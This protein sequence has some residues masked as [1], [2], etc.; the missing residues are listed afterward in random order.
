M[1][2]ARSIE[3]IAHESVAPALYLPPEEIQKLKP[4]VNTHSTERLRCRAH[5]G[6]SVDRQD[7]IALGELQEYER[8]QTR[9]GTI[10]LASLLRALPAD[11]FNIEVDCEHVYEVGDAGVLVHNACGDSR[12]LGLD[13]AMGSKTLAKGMRQAGYQAGHIVPA[14]RVWAGR[15]QKVNDAL[16]WAQDATV[17]ATIL[18]SYNMLHE[19]TIALGA[20]ESYVNVMDHVFRIVPR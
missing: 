12:K 16:G 14:S 3:P 9:S 10:H 13:L 7:W 17:D 20:N 15:S 18:L 11:V 8:V 4:P 2:A 1:I 5:L 19:G 6:L